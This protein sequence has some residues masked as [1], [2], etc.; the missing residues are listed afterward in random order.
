MPSPPARVE[1]RAGFVA[2]NRVALIIGAVA[3]AVFLPSVLCGFVFD[4]I[5]LISENEYAQ[6]LRYLG[7]SFTTHLWDNYR[8]GAAGDGRRYYRPIVGESYLLNWVIA[9]GSA[10]SFH[11]VNVLIHA[12]TTVLAARIALRWTGHAGLAAVAALVF[13]LHPS[14]TENVSWISG[15]TDLLMALFMLLAVECAHFAGRALK[16]AAA[17][18]VATVV[19]TVLAII[20]KENAI[21]TGL[22]IAVEATVTDPGSRRRLI[23]LAVLTGALGFVYLVGR[24]IF[25]PIVA[26]NEGTKPTVGFGLMTCWAYLERMIA[27]WPQTFFHRTLVAPP[28]QNAVPAGLMALGA[29]VVVGYLSLMARTWRSDRPAFWMLGA[30]LVLF[31]PL[32][33]FTDSGIGVTTSDRFLYLPLLPLSCALLRLGRGRVT[34][35]LEH[36]TALLAGAGVLLVWVA[37]VEVRALDYANDDAF[38]AHESSLDPNNPFVLSHLSALAA[39]RGEVEEAYELSTRMLSKESWSYRA[40]SSPSARARS[41]LRALALHAA[42]TADGNVATLTGVFHEMDA[43]L[44][45]EPASMTGQVGELVLGAKVP[46]R[47]VEWLEGPGGYAIAAEGAMVATRIGSDDRARR[48]LALIPEGQLWRTENPL[49][50]ILTQ[51]RLGEF[52]EAREN[53]ASAANPPSGIA[54]YDPEVLSE[55]RGRIDRAERNLHDAAASPPDRAVVLRAT[56]MGELGAYLRGLRILRPLYDAKPDAPG[57]A[58]L[59]V[60]LLVAARLN[61]EALEQA[62]RQL[63]EQRG[64]Q[65]VAEIEA[66]LPERTRRMRAPDE[67]NQWWRN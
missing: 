34:A 38:W 39:R 53:L 9:G 8:T 57:V 37:I 66:Q 47:T 62:K 27:P 12:L 35:L 1:P 40:L 30:T 20:S 33:N 13:A 24:A 42:L 15:R 21:A 63:G 45:A 18:G 5:T 16:G 17:W 59:Y 29:L 19:A 14:R 2:R 4:D 6:S 22:L 64:A 54:G 7:R 65:A 3:L 26:G 43:F 49:N 61:R 31:G 56:A 48:Y 28:G 10:W 46:K 52:D 67:P 60:Q 55:L 32:L 41:Y 36:R 51:A 44:R 58:P 50:L 25:Y 11:L 23:R